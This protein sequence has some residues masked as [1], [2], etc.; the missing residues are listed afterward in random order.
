VLDV[1][2]RRLVDVVPVEPTD[3]GTWVAPTVAALLEGS[4]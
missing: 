2:R 3:L 1:S 4:G